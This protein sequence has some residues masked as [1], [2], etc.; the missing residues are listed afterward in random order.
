[1][2][3]SDR[4]PAS[5]VSVYMPSQRVPELCRCV[6][7]SKPSAAMPSEQIESSRVRTSVQPYVRAQHPDSDRKRLWPDIGLELAVRCLD[8]DHAPSRDCNSLLSLTIARHRAP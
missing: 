1:M 5:L 2:A 6:G 3:A 4:C 8:V 7:F